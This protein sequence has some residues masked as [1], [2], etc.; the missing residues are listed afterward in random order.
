MG[1]P[2]VVY[3]KRDRTGG[4]IQSGREQG[5]LTEGGPTSIRETPMVS[6]LVRDLDLDSTRVPANANAKKRYLVRDGHLLSV[7]SSPF[8]AIT[9]PLF[10]LKAKLRILAEPFI[11]KS[12]QEDPSLAEFVSRRLG[13]EIL[14]YAVDPLV[15]GIYAGR[16]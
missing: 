12:E 14:E 7:P 10:S 4:M 15:G 5:F 3:E 8:S 11:G 6:Q 13:T 9:T 1:L 2:V 16:P